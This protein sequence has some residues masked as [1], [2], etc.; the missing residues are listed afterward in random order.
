MEFYFRVIQNS[1]FALKAKQKLC[2]E[3]PCN[4]ENSE[5]EVGLSGDNNVED[6]IVEDSEAENDTVTESVDAVT[7]EF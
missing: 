4:E 7:N 2:D 6:L 5:E 1:D 3:E